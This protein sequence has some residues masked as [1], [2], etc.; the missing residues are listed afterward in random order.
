[1][2]MPVNSAGN[3]A[4]VVARLTHIAVHR[5]GRT[6]KGRAEI[7]HELSKSRRVRDLWT[8]LASSMRVERGNTHQGEAVSRF[9]RL[10]PRWTVTNRLICA[11]KPDAVSNVHT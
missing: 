2:N 10:I 4:G 11:V 3:L 7:R 8:S 9:Y 6:A 1:M 5:S